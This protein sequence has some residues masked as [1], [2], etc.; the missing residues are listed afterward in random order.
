MLFKTVEGYSRKAAYFQLARRVR[1]QVTPM[2]AVSLMEM[3][4][5]GTRE[6]LFVASPV[7]WE[8]MRAIWIFE[9]GTL[10]VL[11]PLVLCMQAF[12]KRATASFLNADRRNCQRRRWPSDFNNDDS[13][14]VA[15]ARKLRR[16]LIPSFFHSHP[17]VRA[18][19]KRQT[20]PTETLAT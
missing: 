8:K 1:I 18:D 6:V 13:F 19:K 9:A 4:S 11:I 2:T 12:D 5:S 10:N 20:N 15:F 14:S 3:R 7:P 16:E 17:S